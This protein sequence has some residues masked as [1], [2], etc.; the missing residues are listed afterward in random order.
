M[1][2][3]VLGKDEVVGS[4]PT[5]GSNPARANG[6]LLR[7]YLSLV[8]VFPRAYMKQLS[9]CLFFFSALGLP[10]FALTPVATVT[11]AGPFKLDG[12]SLNTPGVTTFPLIIGDFVGTLNGA[13]A[14]FF[15]DGNVVKLA[16]KSSIEITGS[17]TGPILVLLSGSLDYQLVPGSSLSV[18]NL[19]AERKNINAN[20]QRKQTTPT[21]AAPAWAANANPDALRMT[22]HEVDPKF[23]IS[24]GSIGSPSLAATLLRLPA[25]SRHF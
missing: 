8:P 17:E 21:R 1:V 25:V 4:I 23:L 11:S 18:T 10:V 14:V 5:N 19:D 3:R 6:I 7:L 2:E 13:A 24:A 22:P 15:A 12:H 9:R 20:E 16:A